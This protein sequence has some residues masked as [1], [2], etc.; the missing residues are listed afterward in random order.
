MD[1]SIKKVAICA[2]KKAG[3]ILLKEYKSFD[4][5]KVELKAHH[6]ILTRADLLSEEII[7]KEIKKSFPYHQIL[8][9]EAGKMGAKIEKNREVVAGGTPALTD[10]LWIVD[11]LD[12]TT[13]FSIH[14]PL[15]SISIGVAYQEEIIF[16]IIYAP[17]LDE[18][19]IAEKGRRSKL[20]GRMIG[21]SKTEKGKIINTFCHG[22]EEKYVRKAIKYYSYQKL[23]EL[24]CRQLGSAA[25]ELGFVAAG[26][27][28]SIVIP[29]ANSWDVAAGVIL[30]REAGGKVTDFFGK[31]WNLDSTDIVA[32]NGKVHGSI[33]E[34]VRGK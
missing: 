17:V 5:G 24:D 2:A 33:L 25:I 26:R 28:E 22:R 31:E 30:V 12:G 8:S 18:L 27:T 15:W 16:G 11:P 4:R 21:V 29:G 3:K 10:Y 19:Y 34:I 13:N 32:S 9:E 7:I 6:E 20:N 14:N 1:K 23:H